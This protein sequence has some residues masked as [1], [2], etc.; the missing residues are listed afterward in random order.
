MLLIQLN[1]TVILLFSS[2]KKTQHLFLSHLSVLL[3]FFKYFQTIVQ[4]KIKSQHI[5]II[6]EPH[7]SFKLIKSTHKCQLPTKASSHNS[8]TSWQPP[9]TPYQV[10]LSTPLHLLA[11]HLYSQTDC[12]T[13]DSHVRNRDGQE[14]D[15][16]E[17]QHVK[18]RRNFCWRGKNDQPKE[19]RRGFNDILMTGWMGVCTAPA[20]AEEEE[21]VRRAIWACIA[22]N[23]C[24]LCYTPTQH[25]SIPALIIH[26]EKQEQWSLQL[27]INV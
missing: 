21:G 5:S 24:L 14:D 13:P 6:L 2:T 17:K 15:S 22:V 9:S 11:H 4:N 16:K 1:Y 19:R 10:T 7:I 20:G 26:D 18:E 8:S 27:C 23:R 25:V 3:S 12:D